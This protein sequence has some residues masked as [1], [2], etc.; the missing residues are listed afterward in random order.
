MINLDLEPM[1]EFT[2]Q[3]TDIEVKDGE[4]SF[5]IPQEHDIKECT[6]RI[7]EDGRYVGECLSNKAIDG[8]TSQITMI[9]VQETESDTSE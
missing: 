2:Y 5:K 7:Q 6:L 8:E 3:L 1:P 9:P 4:I